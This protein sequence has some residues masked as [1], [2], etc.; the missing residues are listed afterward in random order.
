MKQ[1]E[2]KEYN[3]SYYQKRKGEN[4]VCDLCGGSYKY[5]NKSHHLSTNKHR[6]IE[7]YASALKEKI[8]S[9]I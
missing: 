7:R 6:A 3:I 8:L 1:E 9:S 2:R 5:C 4:Y